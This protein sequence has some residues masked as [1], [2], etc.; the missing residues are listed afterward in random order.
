MKDY[1]AVDLILGKE[2][3]TKMGRGGIKPLQYKIFT[4]Q[5]QRRITAYLN[6]GGN[7]FISGQFV[8]SDIWDSRVAAPNKVDKDF[9]TN[10]LKYKWRVGQAATGGGL[11]AAR[12]PLMK[13]S[14]TFDYHN[15]LNSECYVV[16][17]P[18]A[19]EPAD[20]AASTVLRYGQNNLSAAVAYK[21]H[22]RTFVM[23]VPFETLRTADERQQLMKQIIN[24]FQK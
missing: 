11:K 2:C 16:E 19:I 12:S 22:Y 5:M 6:N 10:M 18:D 20:K 4:P 17:S 21:G 15:E 13:F 8:G 9:A 24:F 1:P 14:G 3:Q 7:I 23:G